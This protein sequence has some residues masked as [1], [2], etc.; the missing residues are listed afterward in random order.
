VDDIFIGDTIY[1]VVYLG[2]S[3]SNNYISNKFVNKNRNVDV[4][5][6]GNYILGFIITLA[7]LF[8]ETIV[9]VL[10]IDRVKINSLNELFIEPLKLIIYMSYILS[11]VMVPIF[12]MWSFNAARELIEI[13]R[14]FSLRSLSNI[15]VA[16][17]RRNLWLVPILTL[18]SFLSIVIGIV[19]SHRYIALLSLVPLVFLIVLILKPIIGVYN[20]R[21]SIDIEL[22]WFLIMLSVIEGIGTNI[23]FL[24]EK[25]KKIP[26]LPSIAK[27][28]T[29]VDRD[30]KIY[31]VSHIDAILYRAKITPNEK[32]RRILLGYASKVREGGDVSTWLKSRI[33]EEIL[34]NEFGIRLYI[35]RIAITISQIALMIYVILP[36]IMVSTS[37]VLNMQLSIVIVVL[38]TPFLISIAYSIRP[39]TLDLIP[40]KYVAVPIALYIALSIVLYI[41]IEGYSLIFSWIG[42][43]LASYKVYKI[44]REGEILDRDSLEILKNVIELRR[45]G[46]SIIKSLEHIAQSNI[47]DKVTQKRLE[48][49]LN[50]VKQGASLTEIISTIQ[51]TSF[52]FRYTIFLLGIIHECGGGNDEILQT[53]Y[54]SIYRVKTMESNIRRLSTF[55]EI[56]SIANVF[57]MVWIWKTVS[58]LITTLSTYLLGTATNAPSITALIFTSLVCFKLISSVIKRGLPIFEPKDGI[59]LAIG[60]IAI[61][62]I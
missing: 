38:A 32:L 8:I 18:F 46:Y 5:I 29:V 30:S 43:I 16:W 39:K 50:K 54:E 37:M 12:I 34:R 11:V 2:N 4:K 24:I 27:E 62:I 57:I 59:A 22:K 61:N 55:F 60:V 20:H 58:P 10:N 14:R 23:G 1:I 26:I 25:L 52:L 51:P 17:I 41:F 15:N 47:L 13:Y 6:Y 36:L 49:A 19:V 28:M 35:E 45:I 48:V 7:V 42:G 33:D 31:F 40:I 21:K 53:L 44:S 3:M 56:F 9:M